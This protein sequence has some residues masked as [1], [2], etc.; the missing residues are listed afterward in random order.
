L[1]GATQFIF[2][3]IKVEGAYVTVNGSWLTATEV[4]SLANPWA[5][6]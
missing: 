6:P 1:N 4:P 2:P 5:D 3:E